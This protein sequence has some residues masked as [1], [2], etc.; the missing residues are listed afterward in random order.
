MLNKR[1]IIIFGLI[2]LLGISFI[3][4]AEGDDIILR[5]SSETNAHGEV[6]DGTEYNTLIRYS[7]QFIFGKTYTGTNPHDCTGSNVVLRLSTTTNA[8][9]EAPSF[10]TD[11]YQDICYGKLECK[12]VEGNCESGEKCVVELSSLTNAHLSFALGCDGTYP[13]KICCTSETCQDFTTNDTC[14]AFTDENCTWTPPGTTSNPEGGCC[15]SE[16]EWQVGFGCGGS[17]NICRA[18]LFLRGDFPDTHNRN[19]DYG[20]GLDSEIDMYCAKISNDLSYGFWYP[21]ETY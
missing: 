4:A 6:W 16:E 3:S 18:G 1:G 14:L 7:D 10:S 12:A 21:V 9:A 15:P 20:P 8:H 19:D 2:L 13:I 11:G 17:D 5:L